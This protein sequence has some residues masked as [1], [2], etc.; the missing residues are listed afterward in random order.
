MK[1]TLLLLLLLLSLPMSTFAAP[2][3]VNS[4]RYQEDFVP[5][6]WGAES[7]FPWPVIQ[8][9]WMSHSTKGQLSFFTFRPVTFGTTTVLLVQQ[10]EP[11]SCQVRFAGYA[12]SALGSG[13][14]LRGRLT[15]AKD[16]TSQFLVELRAFP[17]ASVRGEGL[18]PAIAGQRLVLSVKS[19]GAL[20]SHLAMQKISNDPVNFCFREYRR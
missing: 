18:P 2:L 4:P 9:L 6:P 15:G 14:I 17:E 19:T 3:A 5:W 11:M 20:V 12:S 16:R 8:G 1:K 13:T 7:P 10:V